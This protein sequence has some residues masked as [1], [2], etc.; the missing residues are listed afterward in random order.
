MRRSFGQRFQSRYLTSTRH[1][2]AI[3]ALLTNNQV[4]GLRETLDESDD[5]QGLWNPPSSRS[6]GARSTNQTLLFGPDPASHYGNGSAKCPAPSERVRSILLQLYQER[7]DCLYKAL[8]WPTALADIR[9]L[10]NGELDI[11]KTSPHMAL[12]H[13]IYFMSLCSITD[14]EASCFGLGDRTSMIEQ[15]REAAEQAISEAGLL[16][17]PTVTTLQAFVIYLVCCIQPTHV[18]FVLR[19]LTRSQARLSDLLQL[20]NSVDSACGGRQSR[21]CTAA[22]TGRPTKPDP[23]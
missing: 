6:A 17:Q 5:E 19:P 12:E 3:I 20:S 13:S 8:H 22:R 21:H 9:R 2:I 4:A 15:Y 16:Q 1:I 23:A 14:E 7:V 18:D 10:H 11:Y